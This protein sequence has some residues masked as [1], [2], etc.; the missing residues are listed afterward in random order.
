M[1]VLGTATGIAAVGSQVGQGTLGETGDV[2]VKQVTRCVLKGGHKNII[3]P[4]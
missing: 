1:I 3:V 4:K 2:D